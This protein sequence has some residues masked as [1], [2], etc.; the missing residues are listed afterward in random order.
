MKFKEKVSNLPKNKKLIGTISVLALGT[1]LSLGAFANKSTEA[2]D[3]SRDGN[4]AGVTAYLSDAAGQEVYID[5]AEVRRV[6]LNNYA[7]QKYMEEVNR[8]LEEM[9]RQAEEE[10]IS[11][12]GNS[13]VVHI[14]TTSYTTE[15]G[16]AEIDNPDFNFFEEESIFNPKT[17]PFF[18]EYGVPVYYSGV[19]TFMD[20]RTIT[21]TSSP[22]YALEHISDD[23][24]NEIA[25][26]DAEQISDEEKAIKKAAVSMPESYIY[27]DDKG[28]RRIRCKNPYDS[29]Y[30]DRYV[31][32][33]GSG[34]TTK[35]GKYVD[36]EL[37][38]GE[39]LPAIVGDQ[40]S[41]V[42]TDTAHHLM[43][44]YGEHSRSACASEFVV[45]ADKL[46]SIMQDKGDSSYALGLVGVRV[47]N[48]RV[49]NKS[50]L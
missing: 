1:A 27:T 8:Q 7:W 50:I 10:R 40:K 14:P 19:K 47:E 34:V 11:V 43:T 49:Y 3:L 37:S 4:V 21:A 28:F 32:A 29:G 18:Y 33:V 35:I 45:E 15:I 44:A 23:Y 25:S 38:N 26:I 46:P 24:N 30:T 2:K 20:Y 9:R 42:H 6:A 17:I 5:S 22:Q 13:K 31:I 12:E 16:V 41:D 39:T 48:I 36:L